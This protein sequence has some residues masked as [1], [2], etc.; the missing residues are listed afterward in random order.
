MKDKDTSVYREVAAKNVL[1]GKE[2]PSSLILEFAQ[3][4]SSL[5]NSHINKMSMVEA[6]V[7]SKVVLKSLGI[8][9]DVTEP[10]EAD[11]SKSQYQPKQPGKY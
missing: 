4:W 1:E 10:N 7:C 8:D 5:I 3:I 2:T 11:P 9:P 6:R